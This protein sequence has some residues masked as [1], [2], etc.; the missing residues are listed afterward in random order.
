MSS[1]MDRSKANRGFFLCYRTVFEHPLFVGNA[2]YIGAW[3]SLISMAAYEPRTTSV[4]GKEV[5]LGR[6]QLIGGRKKLA[7]HWGW[8][9]KKVRYF[10]GQ[11]KSQKMI[12]MG[13]S[14][15]RFANVVTICNYGKYQLLSD[16]V[17][18]VEG[19]TEGP[20][21]GPLSN[22]VNNKL[23]I[24]VCS[25]AGAREEMLDFVQ[26]AIARKTYLGDP[27]VPEN[28]E[29]WLTSTIRECGEAATA[30]AWDVLQRKLSAGD[31]IGAVLP[32]WSGIARNL[33]TKS[34]QIDAAHSEAEA[35]FQG[36]H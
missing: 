21:E 20:V 25:S 7:E 34:S 28:A 16:S 30:E 3:I 1:E 26:K 9:E 27:H 5:R 24:N 33:K 19:P 14:K 23:L 12:E 6:G 4:D 2:D 18:P 36:A 11:L 29:R 31:A 13:Q 17:G 22:E 35:F 8:T 10:L 32:F 15:G